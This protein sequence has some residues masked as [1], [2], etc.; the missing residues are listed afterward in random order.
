LVGRGP[1]LYNLYLGAAFNGTRLNKLYRKDVGHAAVVA[2]VA[3]LFE[4]YAKE[5]EPGEHFSDFV[6][7]TGVVQPTPAGNLFHA[8]LT[9]EPAAA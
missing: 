3:P 2:A 8:D 4:A 7:R 6:I 9:P 5:R 1:G